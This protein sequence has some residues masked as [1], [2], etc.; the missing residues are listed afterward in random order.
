MRPWNTLAAVTVAAVALATGGLLGATDTPSAYASSGTV[1]FSPTPRL[2]AWNADAFTID[3]MAQNVST[4]S[5]CPLE[6][7]NPSSPTAS[8]GLGSF[9]FTATWDPAKLAYHGAVSPGTFLGS[10]GR[11]VSCF[12]PTTTA[13]SVSFQC[14]TLGP[15]PM[16]PQGSGV[17]ATVE[18]RPLVASSG[19]STPM[20]FSS[21]T[22]LDIKGQQFPATT[23][24][25]QVKFGI[26]ADIVVDGGVDLIDV[27]AVL[28]HFGETAPPAATKYDPDANGEIDLQDAVYVLQE[29]GQTCIA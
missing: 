6:P 24:A 8:C 1:K 18:M 15:L 16:G 4:T 28:G 21:V 10:T 29:F 26:C 22:L 11:S 13:N 19:G 20:T 12:P 7:N 9:D 3:V 5:L 23:L 14:V 25:G 17:L 2:T 27:L